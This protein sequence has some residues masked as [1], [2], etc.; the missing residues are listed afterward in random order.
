M[1]SLMKPSIPALFL[2]LLSIPL[3]F[4]WVSRI[5]PQTINTD[6]EIV[7]DLSISYSS[8]TGSRRVVINQKKVLHLTIL[9]RVKVQKV[10][11]IVKGVWMLRVINLQ[12]LTNLTDLRRNLDHIKLRYGILRNCQNLEIR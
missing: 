12:N 8:P 10:Q 1:K 7:L 3:L 5:F 11:R 9:R 2:N 6:C 4:V